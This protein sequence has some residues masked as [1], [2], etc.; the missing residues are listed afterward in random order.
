MAR[1]TPLIRLALFVFGLTAGVLTISTPSF[2]QQSCGD[3]LK[4]MSEKRE[5]ELNK[6]NQMVQAAKGKPMN[7][8]L[9]CAQSGGLNAAENA[10]IAYMEKNKDWCGI[11]DEVVTS[12][13]EN[14][15]KSLAFSNKAC[16]VAAQMKKQEAARAAAGSNGAPQAQPL[17]AGPL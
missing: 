7:P 17:P 4:R 16:S 15:L 1:L 6:I 12:L 8:A 13:K 14:H 2:A 3:D 5:V 9:F 10:L 11:P